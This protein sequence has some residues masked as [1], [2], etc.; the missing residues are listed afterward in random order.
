MHASLS[1]QSVEEVG[2]S[3]VLR[4]SRTLAAPDGLVAIPE[5]V[6]PLPNTHTHT[7]TFIRLTGFPSQ[8]PCSLRLNGSDA[9]TWLMIQKCFDAA[10]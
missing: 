4:F 5:E 9:L 6:A 2:G 1:N 8:T 7:D 3:T 10:L